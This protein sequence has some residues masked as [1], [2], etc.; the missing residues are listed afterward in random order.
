[1][2]TPLAMSGT[3]MIWSRPLASLTTLELHARCDRTN[4][5]MI[6]ETT[7]NMR[8][9][10]NAYSKVRQM[11]LYLRTKRALL[12]HK[13]L[14]GKTNSKGELGCKQSG[15]TDHWIMDFPE[16]TKTKEGQLFT[17][18]DGAMVSQGCHENS[19]VKAR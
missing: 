14:N 16:L 2:L 15:Q 8:M 12:W 9:D 17:Q 10:C 11:L 6:Q 18:L 4:H 13:V 1:M 19:Q 3:Y 5:I 7:T